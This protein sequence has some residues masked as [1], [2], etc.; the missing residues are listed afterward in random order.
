M[1]LSRTTRMVQVLANLMT[2]NNIHPKTVIY[3]I[4][5]NMASSLH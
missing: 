4:S 2:G 5:Q 3:S 1:F